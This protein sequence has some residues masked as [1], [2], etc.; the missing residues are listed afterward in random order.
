[1]WCTSISQSKRYLNK[2]TTIIRIA[3]QKSVRSSK[4]WSKIMLLDRWP[5]HKMGMSRVHTIE[6]QILFLKLVL[7]DRRKNGGMVFPFVQKVEDLRQPQFP[8]SHWINKH[9]WVTY[10]DYEFTLVLAAFSLSLSLSLSLSRSVFYKIRVWFVKIGK[11]EVKI[12]VLH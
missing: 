10:C 1:M 2:I 7:R 8:A 5:W 4:K 3:T 9:W 11:W 12:T 6:R